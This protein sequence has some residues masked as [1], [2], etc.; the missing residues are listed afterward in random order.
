MSEP[1]RLFFSL[2]EPNDHVPI[3]DEVVDKDRCVA[4][5]RSDWDEC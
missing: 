5:L 3:D 1:K 4:A 2:F